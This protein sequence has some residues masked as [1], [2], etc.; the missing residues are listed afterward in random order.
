MQV[1]EKF[2][3]AKAKTAAAVA[4]AT[5]AVMAS[6]MAQAAID[7]TPTVTEI[8]EAKAPIGLIGLAV[9]GVLVAL[10]TFAWVRRSV[11]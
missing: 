2:A 1:R 5:A 7:V 9:L 11:K 6:P 10:A 4:L 8:G 3:S